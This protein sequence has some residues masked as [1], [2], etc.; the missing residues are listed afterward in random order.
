MDHGAADS[1]DA[2]DAAADA[3]ANAAANESTERSYAHVRSYGVHRGHAHEPPTHAFV[4]R[5]AHARPG[6]RPRARAAANLAAAPANP[7]A[8][9]ATTAAT[10]AVRCPAHVSTTALE[11]TTFI[12]S[13]VNLV[14]DFS[15]EEHALN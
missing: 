12:T 14:I 10:P 15:D 13:L 4:R 7:A 8:A 6:P 9:A 5:P 11:R 1:S 2:A 3:A